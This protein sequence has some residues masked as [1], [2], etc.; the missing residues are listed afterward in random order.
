MHE[1]AVRV[2]A[3]AAAAWESRSVAG[4]TEAGVGD[5][6]AAA[7]VVRAPTL[8]EWAQKL[9]LMPKMEVAAGDALGSTAAATAAPQ[10]AAPGG[11]ST[12]GESEEAGR[13][14]VTMAE[15][16][17]YAWEAQQRVVGLA[18]QHAAQHGAVAGGCTGFMLYG[19]RGL[20]AHIGLSGL[21]MRSSDFDFKVVAETEA[22]FV[23]QVQAL[24]EA[25]NSQLAR[26]LCELQWPSDLKEMAVLLV[27]GRRQVDFKWLR[28]AE[29]DGICS[30]WGPPQQAGPGCSELWGCCVAPAEWLVCQLRELLQ[31]EVPRWRVEKLKLQLDTVA[32]AQVLGVWCSECLESPEQVVERLQQQQQQRVEHLQQP[33]T[34]GRQQQNGEWV[35]LAQHQQ[36]C[37]TV[38]TQHLND[39]GAGSWSSDGSEVDDSSSDGDG[40]WNATEM[41]V[42]LTPELAQEQ[43]G[44]VPEAVLQL[45]RLAA[46]HSELVS[47]VGL[48]RKEVQR[49][50]WWWTHRSYV[51]T[52]FSDW[53]QLSLIERIERLEECS[54]VDD[55]RLLL[56][57]PNAPT[58]E[59][60]DARRRMNK[61]LGHDCDDEYVKHKRYDI[62]GFC[63]RDVCVEVYKLRHGSDTVRATTT[64]DGQRANKKYYAQ[65]VDHLN[66]VMRL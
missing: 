1:F 4:D 2:A 16:D 26:P 45:E 64:R 25:V 35:L 36:P 43:D 51:H 39:D 37:A 46:D 56:C 3:A 52:R 29:F 59:Q 53:K 44:C 55:E 41:P 9:G 32:T 40:D 27:G 66:G 65:N 23:E 50:D 8:T 10:N 58:D 14:A 57:E 63:K 18:V 34:D 33:S 30:Q 62:D 6:V 42:E 20:N 61:R 5:T 13:V 22:A 12:T 7:A 17:E 15:R 19:G 11:S 31:R 49:Q 38:K 47:E 54:Q 48:L 24:W 60:V 21:R 28:V